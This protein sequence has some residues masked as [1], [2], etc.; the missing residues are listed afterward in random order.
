[1]A[2]PPARRPPKRGFLSAL[3]DFSF[4]SFVTPMVVKGL[5][6]LGTIWTFLF[7]LLL[8]LIGLHFGHV[9]LGTF[10]FLVPAVAVFILVSLGAMRVTLEFFMTQYRIDESLQEL[11][12][13]GERHL[14][15]PG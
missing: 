14:G 10:I 5:Y 12:R 13:Q 15:E 7:A 9:T 2:R 4:T 3:F 11:R 6:V 1:M 8:F